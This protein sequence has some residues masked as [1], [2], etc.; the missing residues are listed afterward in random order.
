MGLTSSLLARSGGKHASGDAVVESSNLNKG[1]ARDCSTRKKADDLNEYGVTTG[2]GDEPIRTAPPSVVIPWVLS[3]VVDSLSETDGLRRG[4]TWEQ[5]AAR[6]RVCWQEYG[7]EFP[8]EF[9]G[10][11]T[12]CLETGGNGDQVATFLLDIFAGEATGE[13]ERMHVTKGTKE[14]WPLVFRKCRQSLLRKREPDWTS[15]PAIESRQK[16]RQLLWKLESVGTSKQLWSKRVFSFEEQK[17]ANKNAKRLLK[18]LKKLERGLDR[19]DREANKVIGEAKRVAIE[20]T[21][22]PAP[23]EVHVASAPR[24]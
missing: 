1:S 7:A 3:D 10:A 8:K 5:H 16:I 12:G 17:F 11:L 4:V 2:K 18:A 20:A 19:V 24:A 6:L 22:K 9:A 15:I 23:W 14:L 13:T 21:L